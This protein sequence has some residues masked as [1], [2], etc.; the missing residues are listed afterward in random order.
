MFARLFKSTENRKPLFQQS[1]IYYAAFDDNHE[2]SPTRLLDKCVELLPSA[3]AHI[4]TIRFLEKQNSSNPI[5]DSYAALIKTAS[6]GFNK[7]N[8]ECVESIK[9]DMQHFQHLL[10][11]YKRMDTALDA[12]IKLHD[13]F[14]KPPQSD[15]RGFLLKFNEH[16]NGLFKLLGKQIES[17]VERYQPYHAFIKDVIEV[18]QATEPKPAATRRASM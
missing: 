12:L 16:K 14:S 17:I 18:C 8:P 4:D 9:K 10:N 15:D 5:D 2:E 1:M 11:V 7:K 6:I 13:F 3:S